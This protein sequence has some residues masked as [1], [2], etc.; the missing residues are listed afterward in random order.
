MYVKLKNRNIDRGLTL[1]KPFTQ[2]GLPVPLSFAIAKTIRRLK[3]VV[4]VIIEERKKLIKKHQL[5][6]LEGNA[7][8]NE[9]GAIQFASPVA[10]SNDFDE[11]M[12]QESEVDVHQVA[13]EK[14]TKMKDRDGKIIQPSPEELEGLLLLQMVK[15]PEVEE[16]NKEE[17]E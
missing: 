6:D 9:K 8:V 15:E 14:L 10:F 12:V 4:D 17:I 2:R 7:V 11:L 5:T 3:D 16:E 1:L 13:Y